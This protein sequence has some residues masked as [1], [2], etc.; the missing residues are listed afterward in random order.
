MKPDGSDLD[1]GDM[2]ARGHYLISLEWASRRG[3]CSIAEWSS[4]DKRAKILVTR[5]DSAP[6]PWTCNANKVE[7]AKM[8]VKNGVNSKATAE[9]VFNWKPATHLGGFCRKK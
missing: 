1:I 7:L 6:A 9:A 5:R 8:L 2:K 3:N 4:T